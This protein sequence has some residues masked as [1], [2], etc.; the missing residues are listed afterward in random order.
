MATQIQ[1]T[2]R[3]AEPDRRVTAALTASDGTETL[4]EFVLRP[5]EAVIVPLPDGMRVAVADSAPQADPG[6]PP[7]PVGRPLDGR[8]GSGLA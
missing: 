6:R 2:N 4:V 1:I 7:A 5:G 3:S 8:P